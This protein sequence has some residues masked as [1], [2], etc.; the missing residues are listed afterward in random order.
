MQLQTVDSSMVHAVGYDAAT[1]TLEVIFNSGK[2]YQYFQVPPNVYE[3]LMSGSSIGGYMRDLI[4]DCYPCTQVR[5]G[6]KRR[7]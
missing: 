2:I 7:R 5:Q 4:I 6:S 1:E 3:E